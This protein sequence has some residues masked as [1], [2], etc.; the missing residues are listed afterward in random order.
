MR[1]ILSLILVLGFGS[2]V[3]A[4][5]TIIEAC[6]TAVAFLLNLEKYKLEV[7][8]VQSF[9]EL[10]PPRVNFRI[11]GSADMVSC[12]FTSNS[13]LFGITQLCYSG[14]CLPKDGQTFEEIKVLMKR[15]GY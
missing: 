7:S 3:R 5:D 14:S 4:E 12:Q 13:D 9:P 8:N 1:L 10:S 11:G 6:H 2:T 15:A